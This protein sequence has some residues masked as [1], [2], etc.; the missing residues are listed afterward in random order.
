[1]ICCQLFLE[2]IKLSVK[3]IVKD[4]FKCLSCIVLPFVGG[5]FFACFILAL[6]ACVMMSF[7]VSITY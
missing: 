7:G 2:V 5:M 1:M 3:G 4:Y 6:A